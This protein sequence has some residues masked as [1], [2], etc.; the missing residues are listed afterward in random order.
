MNVCV[1]F[2]IILILFKIGKGFLFKFYNYLEVNEK[3][4]LVLKKK[5]VVWVG[6]CGDKFIFCV[7]FFF[8]IIE[9]CVIVFLYIK[10][11]LKF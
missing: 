1:S 5:G 3:K 10:Y 11:I 2:F 9:N 4:I 6:G 8:K 7:I